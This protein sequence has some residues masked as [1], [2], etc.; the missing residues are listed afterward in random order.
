MGPKKKTIVG[1]LLFS[2]LWLQTLYT[3][4]RATHLNILRKKCYENTR[5]VFYFFCI[6][7]FTFAKTNFKI[8]NAYK[9]FLKKHTVSV[10]VKNFGGDANS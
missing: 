1:L 10:F 2:P 4:M 5:S 7:L 3:D 8:F 9:S 6:K